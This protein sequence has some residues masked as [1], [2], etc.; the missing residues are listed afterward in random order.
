MKFWKRGQ[1]KEIARYAQISESH[2]S[3]ILYRKRCISIQMAVRLEH[4]SK[5]VLKENFIPKAQWGFN[6]YTTHSAFFGK[7]LP[8]PR[9]LK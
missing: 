8:I 9:K 2:V 6:E 1:R 5:I 7:P 4:A 3:A